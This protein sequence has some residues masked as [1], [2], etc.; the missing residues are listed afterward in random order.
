MNIFLLIPLPHEVLL[1]S[2]IIDLEHMS[3][4]ASG[5]LAS[6]IKRQTQQFT[7]F[8]LASTASTLVTTRSM[9]MIPKLDSSKR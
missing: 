2:P 8:I 6:D 9:R 1:D 5:I 3:N 4:P 7:S